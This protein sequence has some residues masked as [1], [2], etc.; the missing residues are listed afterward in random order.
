MIGIFTKS[1]YSGQV[2]SELLG[3][4]EDQKNADLMI[5]ELNDWFPNVLF[6]AEDIEVNELSSRV[7]RF[8]GKAQQYPLR[9]IIIEEMKDKTIPVCICGHFNNR[10]ILDSESAKHTECTICTCQKYHYLSDMTH[11][12]NDK[13]HEFIRKT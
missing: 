12:Q 7:M 5:K 9:G 13:L 3:I 2:P 4:A 1:G 8:Y 11:E 10:H 6:F